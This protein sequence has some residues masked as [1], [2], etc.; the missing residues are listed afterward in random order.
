MEKHADQS[1]R[2]RSKIQC[3]LV[4]MRPRGLVTPVV[5]LSFVVVLIF[6][7]GIAYDSGITA[8]NQRLPSFLANAPRSPKSARPLLN[9]SFS[10]ILKGED[11]R[12]IPSQRMNI[13]S[14]KS[15]IYEKLTRYLEPTKLIVIDESEAHEDHLG[16]E[17]EPSKF[18]QSETHF[19][20]QVESALFKGLSRVRRHQLVHKA[21]SEELQRYI[22]AITIVAEVPSDADSPSVQ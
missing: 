19:R 2:V 4:V 13:F 1:A 17:E 9:W 14:V 3:V 10:S 12:S 8:P 5:A 18:A 6:G 7:C 21:L 16:R 20:I 15:A 22:H 11:R